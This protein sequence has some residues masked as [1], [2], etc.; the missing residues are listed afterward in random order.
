MTP[1]MLTC[2]LMICALLNSFVPAKPAFEPYTL[3]V[4]IRSGA[5]A[6]QA[7]K[8]QGR[9][10]PIAAFQSI[11]GDH[12]SHGF[13][14]DAT[15]TSILRARSLR[16]KSD[17]SL[18]S[19][20]ELDLARIAVITVS[21]STNLTKALAALSSHADVEYAE[22]RPIQSLVSIPNDTLASRQYHLALVKAYAAWDLLPANRTV[23]LGIVDTGIDGLHPD[24]ASSMFTNPG[25]TGLDAN[26]KDKR[27]NAIDDDANGFVDDAQGWD[28]VSSSDPSKGD[29]DP[30]PGNPHGTHVGGTAGATINNVIGGA[31]VAANVKLMAVKI[32]DDNQFSR[33]VSS[34]ADGILYAASNGASVINC[35][36]GSSSR[37]FAD[38]DVINEATALGALI[39]CAAGNDGVDLAFYPAAYPACLSVAATDSTDHLTSFSNIN[40]SIDV[41]APGKKILAT[42]PNNTYETLDG[43]SMA[44]PI[45]A[46][47]AAMVRMTHPTYTPEQTHA[48]IKASASSVD[49]LNLAFIGRMGAG[50]VNAY[51]AARQAKRSWCSIVQTTINDADADGLFEPGE[52]IRITL[53]LRNILE[54]LTAPVLR[55]KSAVFDFNVKVDTDSFAL[56]SFASGEERTVEQDF[57]VTLPLNTPQNAIVEFL[58]TMSDDSALVLRDIVSFT[59]NPTYRTITENDIHVTVNSTGNLGYNDYPSNEQGDGFSYTTSTD[60]LFESSLLVGV[61]PAR[62]SNGARGDDSHVKDTSFHAV[63]VINVLRDSVP[64]G[65]RAVS[66]YNDAYDKESCGVSVRQT[67]YQ[68]NDDSVRNVITTCYDLTNRTSGPL[69]NIYTALFFDWDIGPSGANNQ[70]QWDYPT[71]SGMQANVA[72]DGFPIV[73][74]SMIS[75]IITNFYAIDNAG[76]SDVNIGIYDDFARSEKWFMMSNGINRTRSSVTDASMMIGGGPFTLAPGET[77]QICFVIGAGTTYESLASGLSAA[78]NRAIGMGLNAV[79]YVQLADVDKILYVTDGPVLSPGTVALRYSIHRTIP[80]TI[81]LI[82]LF[83]ST[84]AAYHS[85]I[86]AAGIHEISIVIPDVASGNY[87]LRLQ[88][89]TASLFPIVILQ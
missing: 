66:R 37:T 50:R 83:G 48:T 36:F 88:G 26:G 70:A 13:V 27:T 31:G 33:T 34:T 64:S 81:D 39:V 19:T 79:P 58:C 76:R 35:S 3:V 89:A 51:E 32:G 11:I 53:R 22:R 74:V 84:I 71:G 80:V 52:V 43:T 23:V 56:S 49:A 16:D 61:S 65:I 40:G 4:K 18:Q 21:A 10:G 6:F 29:N 69:E 72:T 68:C 73:G 44:S 77:S 17:V 14:R 12:G 7:W 15:L 8:E 25:E 47:I 75:P 86:D 42:F 20:S 46:A 30:S 41:A 28:F 87:F 63:D 5:A 45:V 59:A 78:R 55:L 60:L 38:V 57:V 85:N 54:P 24:L 62:I 2:C 67:V 82:D 9:T 1:M